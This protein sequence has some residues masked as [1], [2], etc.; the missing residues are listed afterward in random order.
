MFRWL[1]TNIV[2]F[3]LADLKG[4]G[5]DLSKLS[6]TLSFTDG[7]GRNYSYKVDLAKYD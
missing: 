6:G 5:V 7:Q 1:G 2:G 3:S 4:T